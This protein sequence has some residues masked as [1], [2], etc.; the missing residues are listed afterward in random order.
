MVERNGQVNFGTFHVPFHNANVI[1]APLYAAGAPRFWKKFRLKEWQH[2]G[3]VTPGHYIGMV[4]FDAKF[5]GISFFTFMTG[6]KIPALSTAGRYR[7]NPS[8]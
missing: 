8:V 5:M 2:Y 7:E 3:I 6:R 1:D 4:I